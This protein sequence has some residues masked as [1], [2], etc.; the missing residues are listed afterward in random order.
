M[1]K[2]V[3]WKVRLSICPTHLQYSSSQLLQLCLH[4]LHPPGMQLCH[5][6]LLQGVGRQVEQLVLVVRT[7]IALSLHSVLE[8]QG[9]N[10]PGLVLGL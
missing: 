3:T 8:P 5:V 10:L 6:D 1:A 7:G 9:F 2:V 4:L